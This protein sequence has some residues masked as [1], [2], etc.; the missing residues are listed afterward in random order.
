M[1]G[2]G[3]LD[4]L[5]QRVD[6]QTS[7]LKEIRDLLQH[8]VQTLE[9]S[10]QES[11]KESEADI[12]TSEDDLSEELPPKVQEMEIREDSPVSESKA[13]GNQIRGELDQL[14]ELPNKL[15]VDWRF[16]VGGKPK[17]GHLFPAA[18]WTT[19]GGHPT[20]HLGGVARVSD[21]TDDGS[22]V[23]TVSAAASR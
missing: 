7:V 10:E 17:R 12:Q 20:D 8:A 2:P 9:E 18:N 21:R 1:S 23:G 5:I 15:S 14:R 13:T 11:D 22:G 19:G 6:A 4:T 16:G 3:K